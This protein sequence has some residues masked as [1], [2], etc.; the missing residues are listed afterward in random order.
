MNIAGLK[1]LSNFV[2]EAAKTVVSSMSQTATT[3]KKINKPCGKC[4]KKRSYNHI[5][6]K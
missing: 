4:L 6:Q 5:K 1:L 2:F 3:D